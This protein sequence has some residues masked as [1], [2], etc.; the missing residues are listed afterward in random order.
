MKVFKAFEPSWDF[1]GFEPYI[2]EQAMFVHWANLHSKYVKNLNDMCK[3]Y[4]ELVDFDAVDVLKNPSSYFKSEDDKMYYLNN[5]GGHFCHTMFWYCISPNGTKGNSGIF[6][7][8]GTTRRSLEQQLKDQGLKRFGSGWS[9]LSINTKGALDCYSTQNHFTPFMRLHDPI[10]CLDLWEHAYY[11]DYLGD[12]AKWLDTILR[13]VDW[14]QVFNIW[15]E[16]HYDNTNIIGSML[17][18]E[19]D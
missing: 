19:Y 7:A 3:K 16:L 14:N 6:E 4:P 1:D 15:K 11:L 18:A 2:S 17:T 10:L 12:R 13:F 5:M 9:W 8:L